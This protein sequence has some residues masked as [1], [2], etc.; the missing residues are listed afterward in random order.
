ME[1]MEVN[2]AEAVPGVDEREDMQ[3]DGK[4]IEIH[5]P[6]EI[7]EEE[8]GSDAEVGAGSAWGARVEKHKKEKRK[9]T[10]EARK[11][12]SS[13]PGHDLDDD[14]DEDLDSPSKRPQLGGGDAPL[15][16]NE[17]RALLFEH[18]TEMK[19]A[20]TSFKGSFHDRLSNVE[21]DQ[22]G[23]HVE[24]TNL[25]SRT[26][27]LEKDLVGCKQ[28]TA[29]NTAKLDELAEE[30]KNMKVHLASSEPGRGSVQP[31][32][33]NGGDVPQGP[34]DP[35]GDYLRRKRQ[36]EKQEVAEPHGKSDALTEDEKRTLVLGG[37][38]QDTKRSV[39]EEESAVILQMEEVKALLDSD[40]LAVFGPRRSVGMLKFVMREGESYTDVKN[41][42]W[43]FVKVVSRI[44]HQLPSTRM[45]SEGRNLWASFVKTKTARA[46]S[47]H[48]SMIRRVTMSLAADAL[49]SNVSATRAVL[50][51]D[52]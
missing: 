37:W 44:K 28:Q 26:R 29:K 38:L 2:N 22:K 33:S 11:T 40:K 27:V 12:R 8:D 3:V 7:A 20:W 49:A 51:M 46:R 9:R 18:V 52:L 24:V 39:I 43:E 30:V 21:R 23:T 42:M 34:S 16:G 25:Q 35:W 50:V 15:T 48:I 4:T 14:E 6:T 5:S 13:P 47:A 10:D 1:G 31:G 19:T 36:D 45:G 17:L 32:V 41:R